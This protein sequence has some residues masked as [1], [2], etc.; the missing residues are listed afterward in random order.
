MKTS[1]LALL[2]SI[3]LMPFVRVFAQD[4]SPS[5]ADSGS[6]N[7]W[8]APPPVD[9]SDR[10]VSYDLQ[11][12]YQNDTDHPNSE[13]SVL[14]LS[15]KRALDENSV[16][17]DG[18]V[19]VEKGLSTSDS[20]DDVQL[21]LARISY[22]QAWIQ[23]TGGRFDLFKTLTPNLFFG[24]YPLM[25]IHRVDGI[26]ITI[27]FSFFFQLGPAQQ[28]QSQDSSPLA[29]SF[30]YTPSLFS[31]QQVQL[32]GTQDFFLGQLRLRLDSKDFQSTFRINVAE[33]PN[34]FFNYSAFNGNLTGS[35]A[36]DLRFN[37][38]YVLTGEV[39]VQNINLIEQTSVFTTG[40]QANHLGTWGDL[41]LDQ[42]VLEGQF[43]LGSS[44]ENPFTGGNGFNP[45][46]AALPRDS[47]YLK[48]RARLRVLFFEFHA[49]NNQ[50]DYTL[51]RLSPA[52]TFVPFTGNFGPGREA[53]GP[54][55]GLRGFSY[56]NP[57][58]MIRTGVEF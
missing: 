27:P 30:F 51:N 19:R 22:S 13:S 39:G 9:D 28:G 41:S 14:D 12:L 48:I 29:L 21:R 2:L 17:A 49:T 11:A 33:S 10:T 15:I 52:S 7:K 16:M 40:F 34:N 8:V 58:F 25:G 26:L 47:F 1:A 46:L 45:A 24:A 23:V 3:L 50:D 38:D 31:A 37:Q 53:D 32:N 6:D 55:S 43:P 42:I 35:I 18:L 36:A 44:T 20:S 57:G 4:S 54:G 5:F 56:Q